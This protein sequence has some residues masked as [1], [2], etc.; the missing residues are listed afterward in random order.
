MAA[1]FLGLC[2]LARLL[3]AGSPAGE[4]ASPVAPPM[5]EVEA[6]LHWGAPRRVVCTS[7]AARAVQGDL[8]GAFA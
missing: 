8:E 1:L 4:A 2:S 5:V 7:W 3:A 6:S